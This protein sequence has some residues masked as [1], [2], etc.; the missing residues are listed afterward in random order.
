MTAGA[1][2]SATPMTPENWAKM[3][4]YVEKLGQEA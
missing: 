4:A 1:G 3:T 2:T